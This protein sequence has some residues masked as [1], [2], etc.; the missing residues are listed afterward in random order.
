MRGRGSINVRERGIWGVQE[1]QSGGKEI[2]TGERS[3]KE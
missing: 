1:Q 2:R 3:G